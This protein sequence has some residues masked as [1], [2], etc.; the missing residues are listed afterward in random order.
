MSM[1]DHPTPV[2]PVAALLDGSPSEHIYLGSEDA[3]PE[4]QAAR[5][6]R[7]RQTLANRF[8]GTSVEITLYEEG[9]A[10]VV[11]IRGAERAAAYRLDLRYL[12]PVPSIARRTATRLIGA[13]LGCA[14]G[15]GVLALSRLAVPHG[16]V[17]SALL[18]AGALALFAAA[19]RRSYEKTQFVTIHGRA[20]VL[21]L[22][23]SFGAIKRFHAFVP[24]LSRA[25]EE[26]ADRSATDT[27]A[28]LRAEMREH[29]RLRSEGVL[30]DEACADG[31]GRILAQFDIQL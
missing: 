7:A 28:Y 22:V 1:A 5:T 31:T 25:I 30:S 11:T 18:A 27:S 19:L 8:G 17:A 16:W 10:S 13:A 21:T 15:A 2:D 29:Y 4:P 26:A 20:P 6:V 12:D 9:L 24:I 3:P 23:A 14:A